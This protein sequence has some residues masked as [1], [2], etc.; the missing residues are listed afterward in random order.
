MLVDFTLP[1]DGEHSAPWRAHQVIPPFRL[2]Q[3]TTV[4][5]TEPISRQLQSAYLWLHLSHRA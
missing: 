4:K 5:E 3:E 2:R 1:G